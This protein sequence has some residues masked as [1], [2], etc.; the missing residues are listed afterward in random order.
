MV[1]ISSMELIQTEIGF[2]KNSQEYL[3]KSNSY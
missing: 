1:H 2:E 3:A